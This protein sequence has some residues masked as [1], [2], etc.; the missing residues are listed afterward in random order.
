MAKRA[1]R[2]LQARTP[3]AQVAADKSGIQPDDA[4][5]NFHRCVDRP[6]RRSIALGVAESDID[7]GSHRL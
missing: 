7:V 4:A 3:S 1:T 5:A 2:R 6:E